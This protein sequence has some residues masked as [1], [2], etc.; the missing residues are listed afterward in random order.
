ML[1]CGKFILTEEFGKQTLVLKK[2]LK[3]YVCIVS[4]RNEKNIGIF[5]GRLVTPSEDR[6]RE[7]E[8]SD[9]GCDASARKKKFVSSSLPGSSYRKC[10]A[11]TDA[12]S[13]IR[14]VLEKEKVVERYLS[15][16][17]LSRR[18]LACP[19][20]DAFQHLSHLI[21]PRTHPIRLRP[22][23]EQKAQIF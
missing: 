6:D 16:L 9:G 19:G 5:L 23:T 7:I 8:R 21:P 10:F 18:A 3:G 17:F 12:S 14:R 13:I 1:F 4:I 2:L 15:P 22:R 20:D 11:A